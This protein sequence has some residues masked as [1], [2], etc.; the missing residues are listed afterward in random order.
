MKNTFV[1]LPL[2][3]AVK[4]TETS[5]ILDSLLAFVLFSIGAS[6]VYIVNDLVDLEND[7]KH[8]EKSKKR[9][10][11]SGAV[12]VLQALVMLGVLYLILGLSWFV[13]PSV[14]AVIAAYI[15]MNLAYTFYL[16]RQPVIDI[17]L[18]AIGFVLRVYAGAVAIDAPLSGW[19]FITTLC[20]ALYLGAIKRHQELSKHG[21]ESREVLQKYTL[22]L[23]DRY[24][25]MSAVGAL[26][27]YSMF[28]M[29]AHPEMVFTIPFVLFGM[30]RYWYVVEMLDGGESPTDALLTDWQLLLTVVSWGVACAWSLSGAQI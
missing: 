16:K 8:P 2:I 12:S 24:A 1:L 18:I 29:D 27:F 25:E 28:I 6:A 17:F 3:F 21:N 22:S 14:I 15:L 26:V 23:V 11:A 10:L 4:F 30:F 19:M 13:V 20:L 7:R 9:P 5:A